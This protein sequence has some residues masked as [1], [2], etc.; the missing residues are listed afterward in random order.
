MDYKIWLENT[1]QMLV[2]LFPQLSVWVI[3]TTVE[4]LADISQLH[5]VSGG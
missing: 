4:T 2:Q 3:N 1:F 5:L